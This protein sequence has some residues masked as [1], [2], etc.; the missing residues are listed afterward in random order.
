[1]ERI[2]PSCTNGIRGLECSKSEVRT[3][4]SSCENQQEFGCKG[5]CDESGQGS[6]EHLCAGL[7]PILNEERAA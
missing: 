5:R 4:I 6:A 2:S 3:K 1:V 7:V